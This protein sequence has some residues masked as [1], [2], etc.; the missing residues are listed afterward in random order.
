[1]AT[2]T[3]FLA[4][5]AHAQSLDERVDDAAFLRGLLELELPELLEHYLQTHPPRDEV[6]AAEY[7]IAAAR[8]RARQAADDPATRIAAVDEAME[9]RAALIEMHPRHPR[10]FA[11]QADQASDLLLEV[12]PRGSTG[13]TAIFGLPSRDQ[14]ERAEEIAREAL[15]LLTGA[16]EGVAAAIL[17]VEATPGY[18]E[19]DDLRASRRRLARDERD[20]RIPWLTGIAAYAVAVVAQ[21]P[22][23]ERERLLERAARSLRGLL[24][25]ADPRVAARARLQYGLVLAERG[26]ADAA[27]DV[28]EP[29]ARTTTGRAEDIVAAWLG[30]ARARTGDPAAAR[31]VLAS[32][33]RERSDL[34][35]GAA[36]MRYRLLLVDQRYQLG[37]ADDPRAVRRA[38]NAYLVVLDEDGNGA[39]TRRRMVFDRLGRL[40][41]EAGPD[42]SLPP[43]VLIARAEQLARSPEHRDDAVNRLETALADDRL[44]PR[45]RALAVST[46]ARVLRDSD[47]PVDAARRYTQLAAEHADDPGSRLAI[48]EAA[49]LAR[50]SYREAPGDRDAADALRDALAVMLDRYGDLASADRWRFVAGRLAM[51][52]ARYADAAALFAAAARDEAIAIDAGF[53]RVNALGAMARATVDPVARRDAND[54]VR[55]ELEQVTASVAAALADADESRRGDLRYYEANLR[56]FR[57]GALVDAGRPREA[58][59]ALADVDR[60]EGRDQAVVGAALR[61]RID[62]MRALGRSEEAQGELDRFLAAAPDLAGGVLDSMLGQALDDA[63]RASAGGRDDDALATAE[64]EAAP[65]AALLE[66]WVEGRTLDPAVRTSL[67]RR[68]ARAYRL[69]GRYRASLRIYDRLLVAEPDAIEV[70]FGR[71]EC[72]F[73]IGGDELADAIG[74]YQ[75]IVAAGP[76]IGHDYYW[77]AQLRTLQILDRAGRNTN[78]IV[79]R[80]SR[81]RL[82]DPELGG[83]RYRR[84]FE[85]LER[86]YG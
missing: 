62:A 85:G 77:T 75:R 86:R 22:A 61:V 1:M 28:L 59:E 29:L 82:M 8:L 31:A 4:V 67:L 68:V 43:I 79:P 45:E 81:L 15:V 84:K 69:S 54:A 13:L 23:P 47:R 46:L 27:E 17:A 20:R 48:Q 51:D 11:W 71:A 49:S 53:M 9:L 80:I 70:L 24:D 58:L 10:R 37:R 16:A 72:L 18:R 50:S 60:E 83:P 76:S 44:A 12:L 21:P 78:R 6:Q 65:I 52:E 39:E 14:R 26:E 63:E 33:E 19:R 35:D 56:V 30:L 66:Q 38:I 57:A 40:A 64:S 74:I 32:F 2:L 5:A 41:E 25:D 7:R 73:N 55:R 34:L 3:M 42:A 36:G